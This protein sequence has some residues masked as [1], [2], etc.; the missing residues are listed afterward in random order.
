MWSETYEHDEF[1]E[2]EVLW[3]DSVNDRHHLIAICPM[4]WTPVEEVEACI[5][6]ARNLQDDYMAR[7]GDGR[8]S[9]SE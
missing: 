5:R 2:I 7:G 4:L 1:G 8:M 3:S 9:V 6:W